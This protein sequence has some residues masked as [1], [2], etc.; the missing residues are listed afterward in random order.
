MSEQI[1]LFGSIKPGRVV[2]KIVPTNTPKVPDVKL[3]TILRRLEYD[4][5]DQ[6]IQATLTYLRGNKDMW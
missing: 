3:G 6:D 5:T 2:D 4:L 1:K